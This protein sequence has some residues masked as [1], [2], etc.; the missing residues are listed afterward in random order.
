MQQ[1]YLNEVLADKKAIIDEIFRNDFKYQKPSF[2]AK[3]LVR[4]NQAKMSH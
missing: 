3:D 2:L 1:E 4:A